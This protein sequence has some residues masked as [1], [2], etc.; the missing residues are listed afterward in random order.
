[1]VSNF[2]YFSGQYDSSKLDFDIILQEGEYLPCNFYPFT[3]SLLRADNACKQIYFQGY[4]CTL[5]LL[6]AF[7]LHLYALS[8]KN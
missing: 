1:M 4:P 2:A 8:K 3:V 6:H 7:T 5:L